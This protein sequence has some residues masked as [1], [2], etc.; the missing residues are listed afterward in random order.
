ML[1]PGKS[2]IRV[3]VKR[4]QKIYTK[5]GDQGQTQ[6]ANGQKIS[7]AEDRL[8]AY[9]SL[10]EL[11]SFIGALADSIN[12]GRDE[13]LLGIRQGLTRIQNELFSLGSEL[14]LVGEIM[15]LQAE[16]LVGAEATQRLE[17]EMDVW[18]KVLPNL[19]NFILPGGHKANS[20]AHLCRTVARRAE[21]A[22]VRLA[23]DDPNLRLE[24]KVYLNRLS[25]WFFVA[26]RYLSHIYQSP[27][28][29]WSR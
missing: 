28:V 25:D 18:T 26:A 4:M 15:T 12:E 22:V 11:N 17:Q 23:Q 5:Y 16:H 10:D 20:A 13:R 29:I 19:R 27:E 6:L 14:A 24:I 2:A 1:E 7:K 8:E 3:Q 21:R 9:G